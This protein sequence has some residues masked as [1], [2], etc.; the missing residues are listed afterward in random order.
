MKR[1]FVVALVLLLANICAAQKGKDPFSQL[2]DKIDL[3]TTKITSLQN[4]VNA[5]D[6]TGVTAGIAS[7][8]TDL[9]GLKSDLSALSATVD[10]LKP[11]PPKPTTKLRVN[12]VSNQAGFDTGIAII[13]TNAPTSTAHGT[14]T[15]SYFGSMASGGALP[16]PQ[17]TVDIAAG[18]LVSFALSQGGVPGSTSSAAGFQ[19]Y[20][21]VD[22][23]FPNARGYGFFSDV[24]A[25]RIAA[26]VPVE[27]VQQ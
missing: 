16:L 7:L 25:N 6:L 26:S 9:A 15:V 1:V 19:G 5:I 8:Q 12:F 24:G 14:C 2:N 4:S 22:C 21:V 18:Q 23:N 17:T 3:L 27:I 20:V 13:N 10:S 11:P